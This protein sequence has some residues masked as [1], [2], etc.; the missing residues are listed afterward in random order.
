MNKRI[1]ILGCGWLGTPLATSLIE[2]G[3]EI[4]GTTTRDEKRFHLEELGIQ[5]YQIFLSQTG[6]QGPVDSFL[7][8]LDYLVI[9]IPPGLRKQPDT[10]FTGRIRHLEKTIH[11]SGIP[12]VFFVSSISVF[13]PGQG[14]VTEETIPKPDSESGRQL[15]KAEKLLLSNP[16]RQTVVL[17]L[18]GLLGPDRHP[19][20]SLS[21][22]EFS[23]GGNLPVNL[24][25]LGDALGA[26]QHL[27]SDP[28]ASGV[29]HGVYPEYPGRREYY[30]S[31]AR[32]F[33]ISPPFFKDTAGPVTGK[34][35][36]PERLL[37][38]GFQFSH[39]IFSNG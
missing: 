20:F 16:S 35:V 2:K 32:F 24:I 26:L 18:G 38:G 3:Y 37:Q 14:L 4:R 39:P 22:R 10:D 17:R 12:R 7:K 19:V 28:K 30:N 1:G 8:G 5:A 9:D 25:R 31:E 21:G 23:S 13:G 11:K 36:R 29:Y 15:L 34:K 27:I 6:V 33:G